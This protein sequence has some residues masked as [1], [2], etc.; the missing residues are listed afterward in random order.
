MRNYLSNSLNQP[1]FFQRV[2]GRRPRGFTPRKVHPLYSGFV[3]SGTPGHAKSPFLCPL[4]AG[5]RLRLDGGFVQLGHTPK[6]RSLSGAS[7]RAVSGG[8]MPD[9]ATQ[10]AGQANRFYRR[11]GFTPKLSVCASLRSYPRKSRGGPNPLVGA[12]VHSSAW[13]STLDGN[14]GSVVPASI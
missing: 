3:L 11:H 1:C 9:S 8:V 12:C 2:L 4:F 13:L 10:G 14:S 5:R 7:Q 6:V